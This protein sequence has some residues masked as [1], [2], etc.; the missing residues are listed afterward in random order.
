MANLP[1][2]FGSLPHIHDRNTLC[3]TEFSRSVLYNAW[4]ER[5]NSPP[6]KADIA[7]IKP[8]TNLAAPDD[9]TLH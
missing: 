1:Y 5:Q 3:R 8:M 6:F 4:H 9:I 2:H 7:N